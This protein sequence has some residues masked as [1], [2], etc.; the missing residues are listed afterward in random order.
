[1]NVI[2][3]L[4]TGPLFAGLSYDD[5][6][7]LCRGSREIDIEKGTQLFAEVIRQRGVRDHVRRVEII[8]K[9][10]PDVLLRSAMGRCHRQM[11]LLETP[12]HIGTGPPR[13]RRPH[14]ATLDG[15]LESSQTAIRLFECC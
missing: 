15:L 13:R 9:R 5:L 1:M 8:G 7:R 14:P 3:R 4:A 12:P 6:E 2:E 11:S 10:G